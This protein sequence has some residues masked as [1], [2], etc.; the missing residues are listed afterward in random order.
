MKIYVSCLMADVC[1]SPNAVSEIVGAGLRRAWVRSV[2]A[3]V[4]TYFENIIGKVSF[5]LGNFI[6]SDTLSLAIFGV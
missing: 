1:L 3:C 2:A 6:L 5:S 4:A